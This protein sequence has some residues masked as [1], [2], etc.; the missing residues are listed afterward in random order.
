MDGASRFRFKAA[1]RRLNRLRWW[2]KARNVA[3][4]G[5][6]GAMSYR[7]LAGYVL[8]SPEVGDYSYDIDDHES[9]VAFTA[10][11]LDVTPDRARQLVAEC[12][13]DEQLRRDIDGHRRPA[14]LPRH[15]PIGPRILWYAVV[16]LV[17]PQLVVETGVWYGIGSTV[18]LRALERNESEG[19]AGRLLSFDPDP[20]AG[21]V[22][23]ARHRDRWTLVRATTEAA[24]H[25]SLRGRRVDVFVH[26]T[27]S[28]YERERGEFETAIESAAPLCVLISGNGNNTRALP[29][30]CAEHD[31]DYRLV[32]YGAREHFYRPRGTGVALIGDPADASRRRG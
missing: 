25:A 13:E 3:E 9:V 24:L 31:L 15:P 7:Q 30:L 5:G 14:L 2:R 16:R 6:R 18:L 23:P 12:L 26:D 19:H 21:W 10:E 22:V 29:D 1:V 28:L 32:E 17:R 27:P 20:T 8:W 11:L 4:S